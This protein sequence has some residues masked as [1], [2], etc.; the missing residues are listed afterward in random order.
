MAIV[1]TDR[2]MGI[3]ENGVFLTGLGLMVEGVILAIPAMFLTEVGEIGLLFV[4]GGSIIGSTLIF[5]GMMSRG[6]RGKL[7][8]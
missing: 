1:D 2:I 3:I 6:I 4:F 5:F 8:N 7:D